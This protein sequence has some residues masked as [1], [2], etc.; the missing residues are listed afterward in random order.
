MRFIADFHI[1]SHFSI[2][3]SKNLIPEYIDYQARLKGITVVGTGDFT[4]PGWLAELKEKLEPAEEGL[5][6][7]RDSFKR[8]TQDQ[9]TLYP[10]RDVRF[11]L[12][13]EISTIYK[14]S[15]RVRKI[16]HVILVPD[17][18]TAE[19]IQ[20]RLSK[21]G[22]IASDG[23]PIL[24][25]DSLDLLEIVLEAS[26]RSFLFPAHI[27]TPWFSVLG[28]KSGFDSIDACYGDLSKHI[29]ALETGLSS[30]PAM[31]RLCSF[32]DGYS[33]LSNSDAHSPEKLGREAN[34]F[35]CPLSYTDMTEALKQNDSR[36]FRGTIEFFPQEGKY[37]HDGHRKC[38]I[39]W[40]PTE[41]R[42]HRSTCPVCGKAV[43]VGV[44]NRVM[45]FADRETPPDGFRK[46]EFHTL[47]SLKEILAELYGIGPNS[48]RIATLYQELLRDGGS[49]LDILL[50]LS[51]NDLRDLN[52]ER[53][54]EG[55]RRMRAGEVNIREGFDGQFG[56]IRLFDTRR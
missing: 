39:R 44:L 35:D 10:D 12:S 20:T 11:L 34:I 48:R 43:T 5:Y 8:K 53:L 16:H 41:T 51:L 55:I 18:Q 42:K 28:S 46:H 25:L 14:K 17:F 4:H 9:N 33:L 54:V 49:E 52:N 40:H 31:N 21:I 50:N 47:I 26:D 1:H 30:D 22:N 37:Y 29:H 19:I 24:G 6:R 15:G 36:R 13:T 27:W 3:T 7:L 45:H 56:T 23:R 2:A 32:L 38:D